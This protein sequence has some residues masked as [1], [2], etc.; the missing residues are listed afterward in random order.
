MTQPDEH[1]LRRETIITLTADQRKLIGDCREIGLSK[2][3]VV[4]NFIGELTPDDLNELRDN[5][6]AYGEGDRKR[7]KFRLGAEI[8]TRVN[9]L[10][11]DARKIH[12]NKPV[13]G[14]AYVVESC[15]RK[16]LKK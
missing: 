14:Y 12:G 9:K 16:A 6:M 4:T 8:W 15:A 10:L 3:Q 5:R 2:Q 1:G 13:L 11:E 7:V